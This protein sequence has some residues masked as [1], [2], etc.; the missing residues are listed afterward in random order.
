MFIDQLIGQTSV[1]VLEQLMSFTAARHELLVDNI[2]NLDTPGFRVRDLSVSDFQ[3]AMTKAIRQRD[4][5]GGRLVLSGEQVRTGPDGR[6]LARPGPAEGHDLLFHDQAN[7]QVE[8][9]MSALA[10]NTLTYNLAAELLR[11]Q[12]ESLKTAIRQRL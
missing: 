9:E 8:R 4:R 11:R 10:E 5:T 7:R 3:R 2:A 6:L 12:F 1:P